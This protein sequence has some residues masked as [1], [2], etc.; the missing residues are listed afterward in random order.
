MKKSGKTGGFQELG[1]KLDE[2]A[3]A[4]GERA[5]KGAEKAG[6]EIK[7]WRR[8][9]DELGEKVKKAAQE[10]V[11][12]STLEIKEMVEVTKLRSE[13]RQVEREIESA[14]KELG[15]KTYRLHLEKRIGNV[16]LKKLGAKVTRLRKTI[17]TKEKDIGRLREKRQATERRS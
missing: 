15:E 11:E 2:I 1:K 14:L 10:G 16:E 3:E 17:E 4:V 8:T 9:L 5:E 7:D 6:T 13:M 12:K